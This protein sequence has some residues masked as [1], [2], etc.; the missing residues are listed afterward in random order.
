[1]TKKAE[2]SFFWPW[3]NNPKLISV[4]GPPPSS[5][6]IDICCTTLVAIISI[7]PNS[8][9]LSPV[10]W[11]T[12]IFSCKFCVSVGSKIIVTH[13]FLFSSGILLLYMGNSMVSLSSF[14]ACDL[15]SIFNKI[16]VA[17]A[18]SFKNWIVSIFLVPTGTNPKLIKGSNCTNG[19]G[20]YAFS[21]KINLKSFSLVITIW[22]N[23]SSEIFWSV[24]KITSISKCNPGDIWLC[25]FFLS[26]STLKRPCGCFIFTLF[27]FLE[28][29]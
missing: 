28:I 24:S 10:T 9:L 27:V 18:P 6:T 19:C 22:S 14:N 15:V 4:W 13:C 8:L 25:L 2:H 21:G 16:L 3:Y 1:M 23:W 11:V 20:R 7:N 26:V 29:L 5:K 17:C 12:W